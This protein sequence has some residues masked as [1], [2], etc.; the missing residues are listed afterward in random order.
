MKEKAE[1]DLGK[2]LVWALTST[3]LLLTPLTTLDPINPVKMMAVSVFGFMGLGV[4]L[5]NVRALHLGRYKLPLFFI[6]LFMA[7]QLIVFVASDGEKFQQL[8]GTTGRNTGLITY[9]AFSLLFVASM[10]VSS[11]PFLKRLLAATLIAGLASLGYGVIQANDWDPIDWVNTYSPVFG[12]LGNPNFQSSLLGTL[13]VVIFAQLLSKSVKIHIKSAY[14]LYL[15]VTLYVIRETQ[16]QQGFLVLLIG[17]SFALG[18]FVNQRNR[19]LG[20]LFFGSAIIS[21]TVALIG[22]LNKGPLASL[23]YKESVTYRGDYWRAGWKMTLENPIFGVGLDSYGDWYR[24]SRTI[25]ATLRRGPDVT[26]NAAHNVFLDFSSY[27]GFPLVLLY[28]TL[29]VLTMFAAAK[30]IKRSQG[31]N[32][33][34]VGLVAGWVAFQA[35]SIISIN[36]IGLAVWGWIFSGLIIG[37][38]IN[39]RSRE[40]ITDNKSGKNTPKNVQ[41]PPRSV[42]A[43]ASGLIIGILVGMPPYLASAKFKSA[44]GTKNPI[45]IQKAAY[46]WPVDAFR[47][48]QVSMI[49]NENKFED[50]GLQV[51]IDAADRFPDNYAAWGTI[52]LMKSAPEQLKAQALVQMKR[53]DPLNPNLK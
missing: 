1:A 29:M 35:Q 30:V 12:F 39:T 42:L 34:F 28:I 8:F 9:F 38:E 43:M 14:F 5:A 49:L 26:S 7:W 6:C 3:T 13:G 50:Q 19:T 24:R 40:V 17:S 31:F 33:D 10:V 21:S 51:A 2:L 16:S 32:A 15:L 53:L 4:L 37:F 41:R 18:I 11:M 47:M 44:L 48:M 45:V 20:F 46:I 36:Q 25:E 52:T 23:L 27:G 22:I